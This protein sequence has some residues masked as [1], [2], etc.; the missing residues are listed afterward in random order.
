VPFW[1]AE[2]EDSDVLVFGRRVPAE[3]NDGGQPRTCITQRV[4]AAPPRSTAGRSDQMIGAM[5]RQADGLTLAIP[6][7]LA[8]SPEARLEFGEHTVHVRK[9]LTLLSPGVDRLAP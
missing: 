1:H 2:R 3:E 5:T 8:F 9:A 4:F 7:Q 6:L